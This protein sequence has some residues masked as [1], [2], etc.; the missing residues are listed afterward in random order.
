MKRIIFLALAIAALPLVLS[1]NANATCIV[2]GGIASVVTTPGSTTTATIYIRQGAYYD[3]RWYA[4]TTDEKTAIMAVAA[5]A[6]NRRV[7]I[8]G[9][10]TACPTTGTARNMGAVTKITLGP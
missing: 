6:N 3:Y 1:G 5:W 8:I 4:T 9:N 10:A 7:T 2:T